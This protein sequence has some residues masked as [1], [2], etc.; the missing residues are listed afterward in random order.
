M[1]NRGRSA[2]TTK[3]HEDNKVRRKRTLGGS[4]EAEVVTED[5]VAQQRELLVHERQG[6]V[7]QILDQHD[8]LVRVHS[9]AIERT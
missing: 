5:R 2:H 4:G 6:A 9:R 7:E 1:T 3:P 8:T